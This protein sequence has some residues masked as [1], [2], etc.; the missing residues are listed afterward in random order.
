MT[1]RLKQ[2]TNINIMLETIFNQISLFTD[3]SPEQI[4]LLDPIF[5]LDNFQTE[6]VIF[7]QGAIADYLY[8]V[9]VGEVAICFNP[10]DGEPLTVS[11]ISQGGVFG[12]SAAFGTDTYTSGATCTAD[13]KI[14]KVLGTDLKKLRQNHPETGIL[15]LER[16]AEVVVKRIK[17]STTQ[18]QIVALLD[19]A[20]ENGVKPIGG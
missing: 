9:V 11:N 13:T 19:H 17:D 16:L 8:I 2:L 1:P 4:D 6:A 3:L 15:I 10:D 12:W 20:L 18:D 7:E 14:L 5:S